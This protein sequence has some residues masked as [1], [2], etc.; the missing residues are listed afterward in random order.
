MS[1]SHKSVLLKE[2]TDLLAPDGKKGVF[3]DATFG[4]GGHSAE[5]L[6]RAAPG[7]KVIAIDCDKES[8]DAAA[9]AF[10]FKES[11]IPVHANFARIEE[12]VKSAGFDSAD[13]IVFDLGVSSL[14]FDDASRGFSFRNDAP[15]DMRLDRSCGQTAADVVNTYSRS[16]LERVIL[17]YGEEKFFRKI[18]GFIID[19]R[20][21]NTTLEL[22]ATV[23]R[24]VR[25][26]KQGIHPATRTFQALR[27]EVNSELDAL[28][29]GLRGAL[30]ILKSTGRI[31]VISFHSLED[32]IVKRLFAAEASGCI[33]EN[34]RL[35]CICGHKASLKLLTKKPV[36][37]G[38][39]EEA[40]NPRARSAKLRAAEKI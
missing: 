24:A 6:K 3:V 1:F 12:A 13:G 38:A 23:S 10:E 32:R 27:I 34:K 19:S 17:E 8:L 35:P 39:Q 37:A 4:F 36:M 25:G 11:L 20:P 2:T 7:S 21:I 15:L 40:D 26:P 29:A 30:K 18:T 28:K 16:E 9:G 31:A 22:A 5:I 33:C 14:H